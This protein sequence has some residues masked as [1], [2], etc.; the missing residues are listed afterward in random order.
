MPNCNSNFPDT[1]GRKTTKRRRTQ[2]IAKSFAFHASAIICKER[3]SGRGVL[4]K[5][6]LH[7]SVALHTS[8][9]TYRIAVRKTEEN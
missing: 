1:A 3:I 7:N 9:N 4:T 8:V 6:L 2:A 5:T